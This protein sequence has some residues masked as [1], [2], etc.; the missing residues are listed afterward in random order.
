MV[1]VSKKCGK[2]AV[3]DASYSPCFMFGGS[4]RYSLVCHVFLHS[5]IPLLPTGTGHAL[6]ESACEGQ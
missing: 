1:W 2:Q 4:R 6:Y 3:I 5:S